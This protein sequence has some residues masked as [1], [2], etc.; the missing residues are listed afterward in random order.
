MVLSV[1]GVANDLGRTGQL[2]G[3]CP[4]PALVVGSIGDKMPGPISATLT[5]AIPLLAEGIITGHTR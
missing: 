1:H 5:S 4:A 3:T 2:L